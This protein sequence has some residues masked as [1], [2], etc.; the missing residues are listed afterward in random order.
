MPGTARLIISDETAAHHVMSRTALA[1]ENS[2]ERI[3]HLF[4]E[5]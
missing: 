3:L 5:P 2:T 4:R 1:L